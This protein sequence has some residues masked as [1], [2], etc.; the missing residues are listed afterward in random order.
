MLWL[1]VPL[2]ALL[3]VPAGAVVPK[4]PPKPIVDLQLIVVSTG[5]APDQLAVAFA[6]EEPD[7]QIKQDFAALAQELSIA[8]PEV[9]ITR[10]DVRGKPIPAAQA[11]LPGLTDWTT[12]TVKLDPLIKVFRR[13]GHFQ[14]NYLFIGT[15][16]MRP[17]GNVTQPPI[18]VAERISGNSV[19]YEVWVD[20]SKGVPD[21]VPSVS[22]K[23]DPR[24]LIVGLIFLLL[25]LAGSVFAILHVMKQQRRAGEAGEGMS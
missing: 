23:A 6:T 25:V 22:S 12:G 13:Y 3:L 24:K 15:F 18:R 7:S 4:A 17:T 9:R 19:S 8:T 14:V 20:Q 1:S 21:T 5:K 11:E 2:A 16:P 10:R